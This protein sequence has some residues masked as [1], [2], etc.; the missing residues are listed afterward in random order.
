M[1]NVSVC[2]ICG[3][4]FEQVRKTAGRKK[5]YCSKACKRKND[6]KITANYI[7]RRYAQDEEFRA[8][9][10]RQSTNWARRSMQ[11]KKDEA[12]EELVN[13]II[14]A[15]NANEIKEILQARVRL[16]VDRLL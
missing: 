15:K 16:I 10:K 6:Q 3:K 5:I 9:R 7:K 13:D 11:K 1:D 4:E 8:M 2:P 14:D 12:F